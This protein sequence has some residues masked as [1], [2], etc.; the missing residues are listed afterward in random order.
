M[1][2]KKTILSGLATLILAM[3]VIG[4]SCNK[5]F[6][7]PPGFTDPNLTA[8]MTISQLTALLPGADGSVV[9]TA[10]GIIKAQVVANDQSGNF[11]KQIIV[12]DETGGIAVNIDAYSLYTGYPLG[13]YVYLKVNGLLLAKVT[14]VWGLY[15]K[16]AVGGGYG[17]ILNIDKDKYVIKGALAD[18]PAPKIVTPNDLNPSLINTLI[19]IDNMEFDVADTASTY[20]DF[21]FKNNVNYLLTNC[22]GSSITLRTSGY[23]NFAALNVPDGNGS[24][25]GIYSVYKTFKTTDQLYIRDTMDVQFYGARCGGGGGGGTG[26]LVSIDSIRSFYTGSDLKL[27]SYKIAGVVI[28][29]A[30]SKNIS[31]GSVIIQDGDRGISIYFGGT[32]TYILET[33]LF[34]M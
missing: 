16:P 13:R 34:W 28:S 21:A 10:D 17:S 30:A 14:G 4:I 6:D 11:Y 32:I 20:S 18:A 7:E 22:S 24:I 23:A 27:G 8:T 9:I 15:S 31:A 26:N 19:Q 1:K 29:D 5:V 3:G 25:T 2:T 33:Q 12:Q